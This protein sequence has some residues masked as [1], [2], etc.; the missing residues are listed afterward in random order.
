MNVPLYRKWWV[1]ILIVVAIA[2]IVNLLDKNV[3]IVPDSQDEPL[4]EITGSENVWEKPL[5]EMSVP[6][7]LN[8]CKD[9]CA[10]EGSSKSECSSLCNQLYYDTGKIGL[11]TSINNTE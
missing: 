8:L 1:L 11:I 10:K 5:E 4:E 3:Q 9:L 7:L 6:T 2:I